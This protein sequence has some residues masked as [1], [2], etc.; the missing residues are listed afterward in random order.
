MSS[1]ADLIARI[2]CRVVELSLDS[3]VP[4]PIVKFD[5]KGATAGQHRAMRF[6]QLGQLRFN[7]PLLLEN[8]DQVE[9][10]TVHEWCHLE[11]RYKYWPRACQSHGFEWQ[12]AMR[13]YGCSPDRLHSMDVSKHKRKVARPWAY[14]CGCDEPHM[15]TTR[16]HNSILSGRGRRCM[17][18]KQTLTEV[19]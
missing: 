4:L 19:K 3:G 10:V 12:A 13:S 18:C 6:D 9:Q 7:V 17:R 5:L 2:T 8:L 16:M 15:L 1:A 11:V 14:A